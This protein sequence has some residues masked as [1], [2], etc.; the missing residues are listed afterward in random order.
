M[1]TKPLRKILGS[2]RKAVDD[3]DMI[4][5]GDSVAVGL[6]GGKDSLALTAA[7]AVYR[8]F[9]PVNF[10]LSAINVD[11]GLKGTEAERERLAAFVKELDVPYYEVKTDIAEIV[12]DVRKEPN[13][14]SLCS[15]MRRGALNSECKR[16]GANKLALGHNADDMAETFLLSLIFEGRLSTFQPVSY[17]S[18]TGITLIRPMIYVPEA[19]VKGAVN[20]LSLPVMHNPCPANRLTRREYMKDLIKNVCKDIPFARDRIISAL[21]SPERYSLFPPKRSKTKIEDQDTE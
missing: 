11:M 16:I 9:S 6:S 1:E 18:R 2:I 14:C 20:K 8:K 12:F 5:D 4:G 21:I 15:K 10:T 19:D 3:Y 17:M 7:L 13:P